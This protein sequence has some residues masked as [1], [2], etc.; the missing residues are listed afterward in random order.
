MQE[1]PEGL[2]VVGKLR[3]VRPSNLLKESAEKLCLEGWQEVLQVF[4]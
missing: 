4:T 1:V 3:R 2:K